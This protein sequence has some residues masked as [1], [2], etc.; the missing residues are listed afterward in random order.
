M[1]ILKIQYSKKLI[2]KEVNMFQKQINKIKSMIKTQGQKDNK[3]K[4]EN[5]VVFLIILVITMIAINTIWNSDKKNV[6]NEQSDDKYK[7]LASNLENTVDNGVPSKTDLEEKLEQ[8]KKKIEGVG[9]VD[10]LITYSETSQVVAMYNEDTKESKTEE[11]DT[12]GGTRKITESD[13][14]KEVIYK[15]ENGEKIPITQKTIMPKI[16]GAIIT[17]RRRRRCYCKNQYYTSSRSGNRSTN[18]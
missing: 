12:S 13:V 14:S 8:I 6:V 11:T 16:E 2:L 1:K 3:K 9:S 10:V 15:E 17:A 4:I 5:L 18:T 7:K